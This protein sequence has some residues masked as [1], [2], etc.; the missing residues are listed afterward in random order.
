MHVEL[1]RKKGIGR[2]KITISVLYNESFLINLS[3]LIK[4][5][6]GVY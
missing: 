1:Q 5:F 4:Y 2:I 3:L 6:I